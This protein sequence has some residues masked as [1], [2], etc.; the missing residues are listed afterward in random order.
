MVHSLHPRHARP[1]LMA[2]PVLSPDRPLALRSVTSMSAEQAL[3][4]HGAALLPC[5]QSPGLRVSTL[6]VVESKITPCIQQFAED[7]LVA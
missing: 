5:C 1:V 6:L 7:P 4:Y 3:P 2:S